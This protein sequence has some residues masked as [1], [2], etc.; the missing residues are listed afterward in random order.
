MLCTLLYICI[1]YVV[2]HSCA[3]CTFPKNTV[4][5]SVAEVPKSI[6]M[7]NLQGF[8]APEG[9]SSA[10]ERPEGNFDL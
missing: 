10:R 2:V 4:W 1:A 8:V 5:F 9:V 6:S 7:C 3:V